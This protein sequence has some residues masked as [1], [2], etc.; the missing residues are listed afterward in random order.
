[1]I[2][3]QNKMDK[4]INIVEKWVR[5][6]GLLAILGTLSTLLWGI[7]QAAKKP[8]RQKINQE[9]KKRPSF[10]FYFIVSTAYFW[11]CNKLWQPVPLILSQTARIIA[12]VLGTLLFF[13]GLMLVL[14]GRLTL[15][16]M[17]KSAVPG[18]VTT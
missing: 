17:Y 2:P 4:Q 13:P 5:R 11:L 1:M 12:L 10:G 16:N 15:A 14:W 18:F 8:I 6:A 7:G 3:H 9:T